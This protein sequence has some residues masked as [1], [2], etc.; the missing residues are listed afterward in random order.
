MV[1]SCAFEVSEVLFSETK[2]KMFSSARSNRPSKINCSVCWTRVM[3]CS[4]PMVR[5]GM[6]K[7]MINE[8]AFRT[9]LDSKVRRLALKRKLK[10][11]M[12]YAP[13]ISVPFWLQQHLTLISDL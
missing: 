13:G 10:L 6:D 3:S 7:K 5:R 12:V 9:G 4:S 8:N 11:S 1:Y 2:A